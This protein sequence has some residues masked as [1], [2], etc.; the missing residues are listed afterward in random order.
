[1]SRPA[2]FAQASRPVGE[3]HDAQLGARHVEAVAVEV[4]R[5]LSY[6]SRVQFRLPW[7]APS[8]RRPSRRPHYLDVAGA[9]VAVEVVRHRR[10]R[11]YVVR[12]V[13]DGIVR[14][15][16]PRGASIAGGL[17]FAAAQVDWIAR[18]RR[19]QAD[20]LRPWVDGTTVLLRGEAVTLRVEGG[21][22]SCG[23]QTTA[24]EG[25]DVRQALESRWRAMAEAELPARCLE[26][27]AH[28][29]LTVARV[30]V[31]NQRSRW[32]A[33]SARGV[34]T[35]N[36]RLVQMPPSVSDYV[37]L[38][39]LTHLKEPNHARRFWREVEKICPAW[40][41]A[42]RWLRKNGRRIL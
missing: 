9:P 1:V 39:E 23:A 35:L 36:W 19:R 27:A 38:H 5:V 42:E 2:H 8:A 13:A 6:D 25:G 29:G 40:R 24:V 7:G 34:I 32:G 33:C 21:T 37:I 31:R 22:V 12:V 14:L 15:T 10:A 26:L 20:R 16:V 28:W 17:R 18:E 11:R 30:A 41:E 4:E 3:Q